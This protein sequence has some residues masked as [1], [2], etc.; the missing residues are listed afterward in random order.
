MSFPPLTGYYGK[1]PG[2]G[3]FLSRG[4]PMDFVVP[5]DRWLQESLVFLQAH[6]GTEWS[7]RFFAFTS[8][9]FALNPGVCGSASWIGVMVPSL[10]RVGRRFPLT[11]CRLFKGK[12]RGGRLFH[13]EKA[14][15][16]AAE[17]LARD[18]AGGRRDPRELVLTN[19]GTGG[20]LY[21]FRRAASWWC[22]PHGR[23][24]ETRGLPDTRTLREWIE[25]E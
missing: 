11:L 4:L 15:Y 22:C 12:L 23:I 3:D 24:V 1:I 25:R 14:W 5:W 19:E 18:L 8:V 10:D 20:G 2:C 17:I 16:E 21:W 13:C 7:E 9:R 6:L